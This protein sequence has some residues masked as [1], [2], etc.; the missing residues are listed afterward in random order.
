VSVA[1]AAEVLAAVRARG[2]VLLQ[3]RALTNA[4]QIVAGETVAGS[5]WS[6]P[7]AGEMYE[8]LETVAAHPD[9]LVA[10]LVAGKVTLID[11][12][13]WPAVL[14]VATAREPWQLVRLTAAARRLLATLDEG[15]AI[16]PAGAGAKEIE[17]RLLAR[18]ASVHTDKGR[19]VTR[20]EPWRAWAA[21]EKCRATN[22][23]A[24]KRRLEAAVAGIGGDAGLLPWR[25]AQETGQD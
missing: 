1:G 25:G 15:E 5:W 14:A 10:K 21:R 12:A 4:V 9:V 3:D 23:T 19:H 22:P 16:E 11:R 2:L 8:V 18:A 17:L 13:L 7:R 20:L 6:H 24:S